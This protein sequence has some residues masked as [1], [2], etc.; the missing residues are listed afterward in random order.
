MR[1]VFDNNVLISA[2]LLK[3]SVPFMA[4]QN[5]VKI[6]VLMRNIRIITPKEFL[7]QF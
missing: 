6:H 3:H 2:A 7:N 4:F 5:A 1:I